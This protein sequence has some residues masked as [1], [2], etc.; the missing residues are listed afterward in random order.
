LDP[1]LTLAL[2]E[3]HLICPVPLDDWTSDMGGRGVTIIACFQS[4]AQLIHR[5]EA[6]AAAVI[7]NNAGACVIFGGGN[8]F[9]DHEHWS[10]LAGE[11]DEPVTT[12]GPDGTILSTTVRKVPVL[13][14]AQL[15][16]LRAWR[17]L[18]LRR[19]PQPAIG[20]GARTWRRLDVRAQ[21]R[22]ERAAHRHAV[23]QPRAEQHRAE[24]FAGQATH[25]VRPT[26]GGARAGEPA[27][28]MPEDRRVLRVPATRAERP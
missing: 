10:K 25:D 22:A 19:G 2:D 27:G 26:P 11:R 21:H 20:R 17:V 8:D 7:L 9:D 15:R 23:E 28:A 5:W 1:P 3:A 16:N 13:A 14:A 18:V 24:Q 12:R 4:R 6:T